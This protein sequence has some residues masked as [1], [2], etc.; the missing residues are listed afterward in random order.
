MFVCWNNKLII[1][2]IYISNIR[3]FTWNEITVLPLDERDGNIMASSDSI[4]QVYIDYHEQCKPINDS[5]YIKKNSYIFRNI[6]F[7]FINHHN[8]CAHIL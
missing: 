7:Y 2:N 1:Q 3:Q 6:K 8:T 5:V 4:I